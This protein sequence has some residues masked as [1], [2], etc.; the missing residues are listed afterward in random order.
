MPALNTADEAMHRFLFNVVPLMIMNMQSNGLDEDQIRLVI[1]SM[2]EAFAEDT[3]NMK[4]EDA[5]AKSKDT[6]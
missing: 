2:R 3:Q 6:H 4:L 5:A 1:I